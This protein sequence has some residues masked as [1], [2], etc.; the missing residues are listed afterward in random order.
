MSLSDRTLR[1]AIADILSHE[2]KT[3]SA[4]EQIHRLLENERRLIDLKSA[5]SELGIS[6]RQMYRWIKTG[7][8]TAVTIAGQRMVDVSKKSVS[9]NGRT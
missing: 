4:A 9:E 1:G 8:L 3:Q 2:G 7:K 6:E 5:P